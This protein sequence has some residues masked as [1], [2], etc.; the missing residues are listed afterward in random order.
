MAALV[1]VA[2]VKTLYLKIPTGDT[3]LDATI[4]QWILWASDEIERHCNQPILQ[5]TYTNERFDGTGGDRWVFPH[6]LPVSSVSG[7]GYLDAFGGTWSAIDAA[8]YEVQTERGM[9]LLY[10]PTGF[11]RG[12]KNYRVTYTVGYAIASVPDAIKRVCCEMVERIYAE[13]RVG[14]SELARELIIA[15]TDSV[16]S[17]NIRIINL[18]NNWKR[19]LSRYRLAVV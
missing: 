19:M 4:T 10:K 1:S 13:S 16:G 8:D 11:V 2:D 7:L 12:A 17:A 3:A 6:T 15:N 5:T 14:E 9:A 18:T